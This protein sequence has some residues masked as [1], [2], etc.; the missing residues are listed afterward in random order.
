MR[1]D[2]LDDLTVCVA[3]DAREGRGDGG[4]QRGGDGQGAGGGGG[5]DLLL[6]AAGGGVEAGGEAE[7]GVVLGEG[8]FGVPG[9]VLEGWFFFFL[10]C[11][12]WRGEGRGEGGEGERGRR[13]WDGDGG[14]APVRSDDSVSKRIH[15]LGLGLMLYFRDAGSILLLLELASHL[16][17]LDGA[18]GGVLEVW[19]VVSWVSW[20]RGFLWRFGLTFL[21]ALQGFI[22][23]IT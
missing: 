20:V 5:G 21:I 8:L 19:D 23:I 10:F 17:G 6:G 14:D 22:V 11:E 13:R 3:L 9:G 15:A 1:V 12:G 2:H 18:K 16:V 4:G 7:A